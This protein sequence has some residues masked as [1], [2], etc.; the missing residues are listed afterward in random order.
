MCPQ[1]DLACAAVALLHSLLLCCLGARV[2]ALLPPQLLDWPAQAGAEQDSRQERGR[3]LEQHNVSA[4][5]QAV[6]SV[7]FHKLWVTAAGAL[8]VVSDAGC[9]SG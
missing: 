3:R 8:V 5:T 4:R 6:G 2:R 9:A 1:R 7:P